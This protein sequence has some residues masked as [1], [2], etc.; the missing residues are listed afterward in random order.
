MYNNFNGMGMPMIDPNNMFINPGQMEQNNTIDPNNVN[1][2]NNMSNNMNNMSY[3]GQPYNNNQN[4][5]I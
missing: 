3:F 4:P 1:L 2:N 5:N